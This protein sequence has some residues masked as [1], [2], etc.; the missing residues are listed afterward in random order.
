MVQVMDVLVD[1]DA[2]L[3][4]P[5]GGGPPVDDSVQAPLLNRYSLA[6]GALE[7]LAALDCY[8]HD[9]ESAEKSPIRMRGGLYSCGRHARNCSLAKALVEAIHKRLGYHF[10][11]KLEAFSVPNGNCGKKIL[12]GLRRGLDLHRTIL[13]DDGGRNVHPG[14]ESNLLK[15]YDFASHSHDLTYAHK[16]YRARL[17]NNLVRALGMIIMSVTASNASDGTATVVEA[18]HN[19]Q[20]D[21]DNM[22]HHGSSNAKAIYDQGLKAMQALNPGLCLAYPTT[23]PWSLICS[24]AEEAAVFPRCQDLIIQD[25]SDVL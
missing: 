2:T 17:S 16:L 5:A 22:Y 23:S 8:T 3:V 25:C 10:T 7:F 24:E 19:L 9:Q 6:H 15:I 4:Y 13:V 20:W 12:R 21:S 1:I 11:Q 18:L 14:E